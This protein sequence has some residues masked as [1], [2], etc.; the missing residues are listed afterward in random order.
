MLIR[1]IGGP[2]SLRGEELEAQTMK[3]KG[4]IFFR[5]RRNSLDWHLLPNQIEMVRT[6]E[7]KAYFKTYR[8]RHYNKKRGQRK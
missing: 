5:V 2:L 6:E 3:I 4:V 8:D 1:V 7:Q